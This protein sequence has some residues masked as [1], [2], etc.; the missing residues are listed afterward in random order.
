MDGDKKVHM[1]ST[2]DNP[3]NPFTRFNEWNQYD[4]FM[5]Y[6]TLSY[7]ARIVDYGDCYT[8]EQRH[9]A[10]ERAIQQIV[11]LDPSHIFVKVTEDEVVKPIDI[12]KATL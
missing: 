1:L 2:I 11:D 8:E 4:T 5:G 10:R 9:M 3:Y 12:L 6:N 7:L